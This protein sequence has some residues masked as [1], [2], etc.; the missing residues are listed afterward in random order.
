MFSPWRHVN[1]ITF[2]E[3]ALLVTYFMARGAGGALSRRDDPQPSDPYHLTAVFF[4][5]F[6][7]K[8]QSTLQW[9]TEP[10]LAEGIY[11]A[12][13]GRFLVRTADS[14]DLYSTTMEHEIYIPLPF[15]TSAKHQGWEQHLSPDGETLLLLHTVDSQRTFTLL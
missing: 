13:G 12:S 8:R 4:D 7:G 14:L 6:E 15:V 3:P 5:A 1:G 9:S 11:P 10:L 2:I